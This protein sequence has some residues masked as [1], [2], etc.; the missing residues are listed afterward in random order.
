L[1]GG[2]RGGLFKALEDGSVD[3]LLTTPEFLG[4]HMEK[5][6][7]NSN[8]NFFVVDESHHIADTH[9]PAY[10]RLGELKAQLGNPLT[11]AVTATAN[12]E[13]ADNIVDTLGINNVIIDQHI[14]ENLEIIDCRNMFD[15]SGYLKQVVGSG[16]KTI[17]YVNSRMQTV[18]LAMLLR[19]A[20]PEMRNKVIFYHAGLSS[21]Q[22]V[23][24]EEM[25]RNSEVTTVVST[26]AFG[27]GIDIT[28]V[29]HVVVFHL[30]FNFTEFN[31]QCGRCGRDG[32]RAQIHLLCGERDARINEFILEQSCPDRDIL[33]AIYRTLSKMG[34]EIQ[35][36]NDDLA[37]G[38]SRTTG[39][40]I[41][42]GAVSA[43]LGILEE[44]GL[45]EREGFGAARRIYVCDV[46]DGKLDLSQSMRYAEGQEEKRAFQNFKDF[47]LAN[48]S[49]KLRDL[50]NRPIY[51][52]KYLQ[53]ELKSV[54]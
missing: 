2:E 1:T 6:K 5:I 27:E 25:F 38:L 50:I 17:I 13:V 9:R 19:D 49:Q 22:R 30:N 10:R 24:V 21:E 3:I 42:G 29:R 36:T 28:D 53:E 47:F 37:G 14:R 35:A 26:S 41:D 33:A 23:K 32:Q 18:E 52:E 43:G 46:P 20:I 40:K 44:L 34:K 8:V 11:L 51:P 48:K 4:Y 45:I 12:D 15:K 54:V 39:K 16:A 7:A 31:Q